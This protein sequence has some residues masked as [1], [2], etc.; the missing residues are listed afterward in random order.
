MTGHPG[1][2]L[3]GKCKGM[4]KLKQI[5]TSPTGWVIRT[6]NSESLSFPATPPFYTEELTQISQLPILYSRACRCMD[7]VKAQQPC[8]SNNSNAAHQ[9]AARIE[10]NNGLQPLRAIAGHSNDCNYVFVTTKKRTLGRSHD[11]EQHNH[12]AVSREEATTLILSRDLM[13]H[14]SLH[15]VL[16]NCAHR[17]FLYSQGNHGWTRAR[18]GANAIPKCP[19]CK[20]VHIHKV[21][22]FRRANSWNTDV[23]TQNNATLL[24]FCSSL[25]EICYA[26]A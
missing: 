20:V 12:S 8:G 21:L 25:G 22:T 18:V 13:T 7:G 16:C 26:R 4:P 6:A 9:R 5:A 10:S 17:D 2:E 15:C 23:S 11:Q 19:P 3:L 1:Y 14:L 24:F